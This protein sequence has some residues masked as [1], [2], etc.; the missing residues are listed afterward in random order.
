M[1]FEYNKYTLSE[2]QIE[3][4]GCKKKFLHSELI[5]HILNNADCKQHFPE[6]YLIKMKNYDDSKEGYVT[7]SLKYVI[8][9]FILS[10]L[11]FHYQFHSYDLDQKE[12]SVFAVEDTFG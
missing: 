6:D 5:K 3:C 11:H 8:F 10:Y 1:P 7:D 2:N 12:K 4:K 9:H